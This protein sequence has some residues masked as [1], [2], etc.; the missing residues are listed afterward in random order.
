[1]KSDAKFE[2]KPIC[3]FKNDKDLVNFDLS[4]LKSQKFAVRLIT[5]VNSI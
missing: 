5:F 4:T 3:S 1:M 2:E